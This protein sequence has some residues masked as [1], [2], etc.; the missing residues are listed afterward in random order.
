MKFVNEEKQVS[1]DVL[2][3]LKGIETVPSDLLFAEDLSLDV[4]SRL[5]GIETCAPGPS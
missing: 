4:L 3:R 2:S 1:L 5:K